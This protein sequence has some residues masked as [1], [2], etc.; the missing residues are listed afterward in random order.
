M[1]EIVVEVL[2]N[3]TLLVLASPN[4]FTICHLVSPKYDVVRKFP[5]EQIIVVTRRRA[6]ELRAGRVQTKMALH[7]SGGLLGV[8][9]VHAFL[10]SQ[11]P[12][13]LLVGTIP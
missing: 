1:T 7:S 6:H 10:G 4:I 13:S 5:R 9:D 8:C 11:C 2:T 12:L 3:H